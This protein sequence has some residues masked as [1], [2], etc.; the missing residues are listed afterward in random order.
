M[1]ESKA[2][3]AGMSFPERHQLRQEKA[4]PILT[5]IKDWLHQN[6]TKVL[7]ASLM[8]KAINY[9]VGMWPRLQR[10]I[11]DGRFEIDNN[12]IENAI[13]PIALGRKNYLFAGSHE[14]AGRAG[15]IYSLVA[16]AKHHDV[17]P[18]EY[19]EFVINDISDYPFK[20]LIDLLPQNW[21][22]KF[23]CPEANIPTY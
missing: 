2:R 7:P 21:K 11:T 17:N 6:S 23:A 16:T 12:L 9:T 14:A 4:A 5:E 3:Q 8:G 22:T 13:R 1:V 18:T 10:Y 20:H 15:L 19:L